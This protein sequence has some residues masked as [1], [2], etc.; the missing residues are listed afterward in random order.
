[1]T[2]ESIAAIATA[3]GAGAIAVIRVSGSEALAICKKALKAEKK[4]EEASARSAF[5]GKIYSAQEDV[6]DEVLVTIFRAPKSFTGEDVVEVACHGGV[7]VTRKVLQRLLECGARSAEAGEFSR[8]AFENGQMD[9]TQAE[10]IMDIISA[11]TDLALRAAQEQLGGRLGQDSEALREKLIGLVAHVEA[12]ID[13]PDEDI[14]PDT[15]NALVARMTE[16]LDKIDS[17]LATAEQGRIL[18]EGVRTVICGEPNVGKSSLLNALLGY[19]R[20]I[21]SDVAGTTRDTV[22]EVV[23][24][25]GIPLRLVD[26]A[27]VRESED[28]IE[29]AGIERSEKMIALAD[30]IIEV[31][32]G[33]TPG[34]RLLTAE[35]YAGK[36]H[37]LVINKAD[38][39]EHAAW[40]GAEGLRLSCVHA[41]EEGGLAEFTERIAEEL[42]LSESAWGGHA[43][44]IN[45]R[46]QDCLRRAKLALKAAKEQMEA[47]ESGEFISLDLREAMEALGEMAGKVDAEEI[48]GAIF[49]TFCI[50]K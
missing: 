11:Q 21:V 38:L 8:R 9:L 24:V 34:Q 47:G 36:H 12:F 29:K 30:L 43:V 2:T 1:M 50:G 18:R 46:H 35:Q 3:P 5:L 17:M 48:L 42:A 28:V 20:A 14:D 23:N 4:V 31:V 39:G 25:K 27:G 44:A 6:I 13:F 22:E 7:L 45:A 26:T 10:A 37:I 40:Q 41:A 15:G 16:V 49:G 32:D 19:E 33:S